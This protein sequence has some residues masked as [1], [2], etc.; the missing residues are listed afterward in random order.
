MTIL[1]SLVAG[2]LFGAGLTLSQMVHPAKVAAFLDVA[3]DWDPSLA[4][5]M[6]AALGVTWLAYRRVLRRSAPFCEPRFHVSASRAVDRSLIGGSALFGVGWG[7][8]GLCPG[9]AVAG[10]GLGG[11]RSVTFLAAM[12]AAIAL[13]EGRDR[14]ARALPRPLAR[15]GARGS[16]GFAS[17]AAGARA[18]RTEDAR[19]GSR[20][21]CED[22]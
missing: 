19:A 7:L 8:A 11:W 15:G 4:L 2:L 13:W 9:P 3:G 14:L 21:L 22:D 12:T 10:L 6:A 16:D 5:V 18:Y 1:A 20:E 17:P